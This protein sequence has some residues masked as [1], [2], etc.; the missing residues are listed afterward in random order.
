MKIK[1]KA[2][3]VLKL[4]HFVTIFMWIGGAVSMMV[5]ML[6]NP[7]SEPVSMQTRAEMLAA[8]DG[9]LVTPGAIATVFVG[10]LYGIFTGWGFFKHGWIVAKWILTFA[11]ILSGTF[12]M[13]PCVHANVSITDLVLYEQ[14]VDQ[15]VFW[16]WIQ[17]ALLGITVILSIWKPK[18]KKNG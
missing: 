14:N 8:I 4:L 3:K 12:A 10:L 1:G 9:T 17:L 15:T 6:S 18:A 5:I 11:M 7:V 16:G 13:G 2:L